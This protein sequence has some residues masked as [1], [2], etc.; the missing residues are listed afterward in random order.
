MIL[1]STSLQYWTRETDGDRQGRTRE[2]WGNIGQH[3]KQGYQ[4]KRGLTVVKF[5]VDKGE[6]KGGIW[7]L[8]RCLYGWLQ[9]TSKHEEEVKKKAPRCL[10][11]N[12][13][14][15]VDIMGWLEVGSQHVDSEWKIS[16]MEIGHE[17][18]W[19]QRQTAYMWCNHQRGSSG[20]IIKKK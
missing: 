16:R 19:N 2:K 8:V 6:F 17:G 1:V 18:P 15:Q 12:L 9:E 11:V 3:D 7:E 20:G 4:H 5:S 14:R 10:F 13:T